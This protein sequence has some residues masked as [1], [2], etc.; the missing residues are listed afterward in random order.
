MYYTALYVSISVRYLVITDLLRDIVFL[1]I[2]KKK[3]KSDR[4]TRL[5]EVPLVEPQ[6]FFIL[7]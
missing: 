5:T 6:T 7:A 3:E 4:P 2:S 1:M